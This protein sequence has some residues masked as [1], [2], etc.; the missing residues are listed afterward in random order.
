MVFGFSSMALNSISVIGGMSTERLYLDLFLNL[1]GSRIPA[2]WDGWELLCEAVH[3]NALHPPPP[4]TALPL[5]RTGDL[6]GGGEVF[7]HLVVSLTHVRH[8]AA[9]HQILADGTTFLQTN[10]KVEPGRI[11]A[12]GGLPCS[13][14]TPD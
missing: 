12:C 9:G 3:Q 1:S 7:V 14:Q 10:S 11:K 13:G 4:G 5:H 6:G 8:G 2:F